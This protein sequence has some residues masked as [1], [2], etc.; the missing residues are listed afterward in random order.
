M[1][2]PVASFAAR[3]RCGWRLALLGLVGGCAASAVTLSSGVVHVSFITDETCGFSNP[4]TVDARGCR[5]LDEKAVMCKG[6]GVIDGVLFAG[7]CEA[8][9][10]LDVLETQGTM[11][12]SPPRGASTT[13]EEVEAAP[14]TRDESEAS[15]LPE[16]SAEPAPKVEKR[17][18]SATKS[19]SVKGAS[20]KKAKTKKTSASKR[21]KSPE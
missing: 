15:E 10:D 11:P 12:L 21:K 18:R 4:Y 8:P 6:F 9:A 13:D 19:S 20:S 14:A 3:L 5:R 1:V 16:A 17:T 2:L 7:G